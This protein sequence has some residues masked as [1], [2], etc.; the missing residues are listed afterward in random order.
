MTP[1]EQAALQQAKGARAENFLIVDCL[2]PGQIRSLGRDMSYM[3]RREAIK[4]SANDCER[5]GG[6][7]VALDRSNYATAP[8]VW[9][10]LV[11]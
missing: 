6:E 5:R 2:L 7:Y 4:T 10:P 3:S 9:L 1:Y 8:K 11:A